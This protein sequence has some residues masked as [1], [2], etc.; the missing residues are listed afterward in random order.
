[1]SA[2]ILILVYLSMSIT[3]VQWITDP[4]VSGVT[5]L[6]FFALVVIKLL[7]TLL[8]LLQWLNEYYEIT[9]LAV[10]HRKGVFFKKEMK[11]TLAHIQMVS[12][13]QTFLGKYFNY[14]TVS[15]FDYRRNKYEDMYLIHN[16]VRYARV[17]EGLLPNADERKEFFRG[18]IEQSTFDD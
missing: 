2:V 1:M 12:V 10:Y 4:S 5:L 8:V 18:G 3:A 17:I 11:Y 6:V 14:G 7:V 13:N 9:P 16:P 15:M